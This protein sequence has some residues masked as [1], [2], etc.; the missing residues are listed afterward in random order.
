M[1]A[2]R[3]RVRRAVVAF[4]ARELDEESLRADGWVP[5]IGEVRWFATYTGPP[6]FSGVRDLGA[7]SCSR[8]RR[9]GPLI[10]IF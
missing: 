3:S 1:S 6:R 2:A 4:L 8:R 7:T 5:E 10:I 9:A